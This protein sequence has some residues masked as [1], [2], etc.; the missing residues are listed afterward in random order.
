MY[1]NGRDFF[2][3]KEFDFYSSCFFNMFDDL[4]NS[5]YENI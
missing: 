3:K 2:Y 5:N 1:L 4:Y